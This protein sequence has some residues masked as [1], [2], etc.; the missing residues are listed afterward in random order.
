MTCGKEETFH[1]N[2]WTKSSGERG[3]R[4]EKERE[5]GKEN[6]GE[7]E[8][9][10]KLQLLF[11]IRGDQAFSFGRSVKPRKIRIFKKG[12]MVILVKIWIFFL[13][14]MAKQT[15]PLELSREI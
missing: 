7:E 2:G 13:S 3:K 1:L 11:R 8:R 9:S 12:K 6:K 14:R 4:R 15:S 5:R 10:E